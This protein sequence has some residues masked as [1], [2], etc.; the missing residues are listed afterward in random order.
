MIAQ[1]V[2][3][4][5][6]GTIMGFARTI[7]AMTNYSKA[8]RGFPAPAHKMPPMTGVFIGL[9]LCVP[10]WAVVAVVLT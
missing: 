3:T 4:T 8:E 6:P 7:V 1:D 9:A 2:A 10:F 5:D